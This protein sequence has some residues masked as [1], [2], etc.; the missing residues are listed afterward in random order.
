M[1]FAKHFGHILT[2]DLRILKKNEESS[3][4]LAKFHVGILQFVLG[5]SLRPVKPFFTEK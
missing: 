5:G 3:E 1:S 4:F 2:V